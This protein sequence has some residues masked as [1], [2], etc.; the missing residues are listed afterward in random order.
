MNV[1]SD[2]LQR[3]PEEASRRIALSYL[4][5]AHAG[6]VRLGDPHDEE[7]LHDFRVA[8]RRLRSTVRAWSAPLE[9]SITKKQRRA[10]KDLQRAT[11][12]GRDAEVL[13]EWLE[14]ARP[15]LNTRHRAGLDWLVEQLA[16]RRDAAY[17]H[18]REHVR[19]AFARLEAKLRE[20]L[21]RLTLNVDLLA[22][23]ASATY[24]CALAHH[25]GEHLEELA[26]ALERIDS[27]A[28]HEQAHAARIRGK[29][30]RYLVE[31]VA[32]HLAEARKVVKRCKQL[33][34]LLGDFN[35]TT[36]L[37]VELAD[38][39]ERAAAEHARHLHQHARTGAPE[40]PPNNSRVQ[41]GLVAL[42]RYAQANQD[43]LFANLQHGWLAP[44]VGGLRPLVAQLQVR[45]QQ[46][47]G[48][49]EPETIPPHL[50]A[51][52]SREHEPATSAE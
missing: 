39:T 29:R 50:D 37:L 27:V 23:P 9:G 51:E 46:E 34:D 7:A 40:K 1:H 52:A 43:T 17:G 18:V 33:Q 22:Q 42:T 20:R 4:D 13:V 49:S 6:A 2:I 35:D 21:R 31:P 14:A 24:A 11:G 10:L 44:D 48:V 5:A 36:Q 32:P 26:G 25:S 8:I 15:E 12:A 41:T 45:L 38:A 16:Q 30:L 47:V 19:A 3:P 28:D